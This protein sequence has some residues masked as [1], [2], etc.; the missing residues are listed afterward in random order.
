LTGARAEELAQVCRDDIKTDDRILC[1]QI[2]GNAE[3]GTRVKNKASKR[4]IPVPEP[5]VRIMKFLMAKKKNKDNIWEFAKSQGEKA[6]F[7]RNAARWWNRYVKKKLGEGAVTQFQNGQTGVKVFH[8]FRHTIATT[9]KNIGISKEF[10]SEILG[11]EPD[12]ATKNTTTHYQSKYPPSELAPKLKSINDALGV[13]WK[14]VA[15]QVLAE[16]VKR[17]NIS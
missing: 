17:R 8:S 4:T 7:S 6:P 10:V 14:T 3:L 16:M 15:D 9:G 13:D 2:D 1:L 5:L 11:H 12:E